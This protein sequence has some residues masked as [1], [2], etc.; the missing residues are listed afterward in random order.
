MGQ[1][2]NCNRLLELV[3]RGF[4]I[5]YPERIHLFDK[6]FISLSLAPPSESSNI[7]KYGEAINTC[8][9]GIE[10]EIKDVVLDLTPGTNISLPFTGQPY[11]EIKWQVYADKNNDSDAVLWVYALVIKSG[12]SLQQRIPLFAVPISIEVVDL[13]GISPL[14][15][16]Y[17]LLGITT[18]LAILTISKA[19]KQGNVIIDDHESIS[20]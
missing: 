4:I 18:L 15:I 6:D 17:A 14:A 5:E 16:R 3:S 1:Y 9:V 2:E 12:S 20:K 19:A 7:G 11:Q 13:L 8:S 10:A